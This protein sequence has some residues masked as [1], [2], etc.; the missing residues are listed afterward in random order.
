LLALDPQG[1][2]PPA[3]EPTHRAIGAG[4]SSRR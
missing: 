3:D 2:Q 4:V 1:S